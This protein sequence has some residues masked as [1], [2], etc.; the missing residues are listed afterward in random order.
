MSV[1]IAD[2]TAGFYWVRGVLEQT[3][4]I[5][6]WS[7]TDQDWAIVGSPSRYTDR[8]LSEIGYRVEAECVPVTESKLRIADLAIEWNGVRLSLDECDRY[9]KTYEDLCALKDRLNNG[10][11]EA[12]SLHLAEFGGEEGRG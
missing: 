8:N 1:A 12:I 7:S 9:D 5:G 6:W 4:T 2:R 3:W 11:S 10:L